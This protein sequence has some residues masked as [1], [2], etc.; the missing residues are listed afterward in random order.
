MP[1]YILAQLAP[2][3]ISISITFYDNWPQTVRR[4]FYLRNLDGDDEA[5]QLAH[6]TQTMNSVVAELHHISQYGIDKGT[7]KLNGKKAAEII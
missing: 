7:I 2:F 4:N 3:D 5:A 1:E 6:A